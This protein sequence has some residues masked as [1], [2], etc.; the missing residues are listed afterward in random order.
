MFSLI[1]ILTFQ[2]GFGR[3]ATLYA[4]HPGTVMVTCEKINPDWTHSWIKKSYSGREEQ[5]ILKKYFNVIP[6][7]QHNRFKL[8]DTV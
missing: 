3:N 2:V 6:K 7:P 5:T 8:L 4:I 1:L